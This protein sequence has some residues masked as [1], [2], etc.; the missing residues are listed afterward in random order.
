VVII[1][2]TPYDL[3]TDIGIPAAAPRRQ[4]DVGQSQ[5]HRELTAS[6]EG[7]GSGLARI[8]GTKDGTPVIQTSVIA[9]HLVVLNVSRLRWLTPRADSNDEPAAFANRRRRRRQ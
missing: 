7:A 8:V 9:K 1:P 4:A 6:L 5:D 3:K 2:D